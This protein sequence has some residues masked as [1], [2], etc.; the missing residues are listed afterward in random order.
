[1]IDM[2]INFKEII[3]IKSNVALPSFHKFRKT[4]EHQP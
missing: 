3:I 1:M 2:I 4:N